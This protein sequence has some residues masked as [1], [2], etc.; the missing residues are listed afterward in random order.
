MLLGAISKLEDSEGACIKALRLF[1]DLRLLIADADRGRNAGRRVADRDGLF[2]A[3]ALA[4]IPLRK[5]TALTVGV[6][7]SS[8]IVNP[9]ITIPSR[10]MSRQSCLLVRRYD[11]GQAGRPNPPGRSS[12]PPSH[13]WSSSPPW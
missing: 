7:V 6:T 8:G 13:T 9:W 4:S 2:D 10:R 1:T 11:C 5:P 3:Y 12:S